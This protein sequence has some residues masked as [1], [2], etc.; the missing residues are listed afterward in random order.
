MVR[1]RFS[2]EGSLFFFWRSAGDLAPPPGCGL[3]SP[4]RQTWTVLLP[5]PLPL[6]WWLPRAGSLDPCAPGGSDWKS[7]VPRRGTGQARLQTSR[8]QDHEIRDAER[9]RAAAHKQVRFCPRRIGLPGPVSCTP[10]NGGPGPTPPVRGRC[11][12][13]RDREGRDGAVAQWNC[14]CAAPGDS[15]GELPRRGKRGWPGP[16]V[17]F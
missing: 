8:T 1:Y 9:Q 4:A 10:V 15:Q 6:T 3:L 2:T 16:L 13:K 5:A 12:A 17:T 11:R 14:A 7:T